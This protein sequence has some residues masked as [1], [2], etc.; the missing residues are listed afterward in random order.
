MANVAQEIVDINDSKDE[1]EY[2]D[3]DTIGQSAGVC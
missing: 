3:L 2:I 1:K